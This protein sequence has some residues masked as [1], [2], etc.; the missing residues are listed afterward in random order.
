MIKKKQLIK[1]LF[2]FTLILYFLSLNSSNVLANPENNLIELTEGQLEILDT[3]EVERFI[4]EIDRE[5]AEFIP[6]FTIE[7]FITNLKNG[8][9]HLNPQGFLNGIGKF[10]MR[11]V[12]ANLA[13][14]GKLIL[15]AIIC[16]VLSNLQNAF[17]QD[18][19][20]KLAHM[21]SFLVLITLAVGSFQM[22]MEIGKVTIDRMVSFM[23]ILMPVLLALLAALGAFT[24]TAILHPFILV[25]L[26]ILSTFFKVIISVY[27]S[28]FSY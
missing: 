7:Q 16:A 9:I 5:L 24:T 28:N 11:E 12:G 14:M 17:E 10:L 1:L 6:E 4:N 23:Q 13:L 20:S 15:L 25:T 3:R 19:I 26:G 18:N 27:F 21:V 8:D 22:T 2:L